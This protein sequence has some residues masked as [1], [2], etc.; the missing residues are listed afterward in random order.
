ML[1]EIRN[2]FN[3]A[4]TAIRLSEE[5]LSR[6]L[7]A[8]VEMVCRCLRDGGCV[9]VFGNGG[10]AA[11]SQHLAAELVGRFLVDRPALRAV[12]LTVD[13]SI[14][15]AVANDYGFEQVFSRQLEGLA[16]AGDVAIA[17]STSGNSP[18]VTTALAAARRMG[19]GTIAFTGSGGG[20]CAELA[21]VLL[22]VPAKTSPRIQE[23][24]AVMYHILCKH[25]EG[26]MAGG[27]QA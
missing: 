5:H 20:Q 9:F 21:D 11:D 25:V 18:N 7:V 19:L 16:R 6:R 12:A 2:D 4:L 14:L 3:D 1:D 10:S 23:A 17:L 8:A 27:K 22:D 15:T 26:A 13:T 24:H